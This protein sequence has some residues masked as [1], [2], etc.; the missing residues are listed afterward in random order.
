MSEH[1]HDPILT[2]RSATATS[3]RLQPAPGHSSS[4]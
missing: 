4:C 2:S 3:R 1:E